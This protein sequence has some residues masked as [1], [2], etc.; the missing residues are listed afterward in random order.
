VVFR[1]AACSEDLHA[2]VSVHL[3]KREACPLR[4][5]IAA[6]LT[7]F[8]VVLAIPVAP[9]AAA[10]TVKVVI[11]VGPVGSSTT[12]YKADAA[13]VAAEARRY[14]SNV[15]TLSTPNATWSK[16]KA[17]AQGASVLVYLGHGN[18][19]PS[20]YPPFQ[21][22]TKD[23]LG[24]D[25]STGANGTKTVYYGESY[26]GANIRLAPNAVVILYHL[27]YASGNTQPGLA[28][29]TFA[30][31][32]LRV[33]NYGAGFIAAGARAVFAEGHPSHPAADYI[34]QL[35]TTSR[36]MDQV[37]RAA[38]SRHGH[39]RGPY[40]SQRT[41]GLRFEMDPD[42][43]TPSGFYRSLVGDLGLTANVVT[44]TVPPATGT[45]PADFVVPGAAEVTGATG[46]GRFATAE[47][48]ADPAAAPDSTL[49]KATRLRLT[50][51]AAPMAD[52]TRVFG[53]TVIGGTASGFV[54]AAGIAPRDSAHPTVWTLDQGT[55]LS[56]NADGINDT[57]VVAVRVSEVAAVSLVVKN[58]AGTTVRSVSAS[59]DIVRFTWDL[60]TSAGVLVPD[61]DYPWTLRAR[62][63]WGNATATRTGS[64]TVD[65]TPPAS[66]AST[67]ST[68][69]LG[70]WS[71]TP[72]TVTLAATDPLTG[73]GS[74][75]WRVDGGATHTYAGPF[76]VAVNGTPHVQYRA[77]DRAGNQEAWHTLA[78]KIDTT[79]PAI[80]IPLTGTAGTTAGTWRGP[81]S[82][83]AKVTDATSGVAAR[84]IS[85][86][87][88]PAVPLGD[89]PVV[90]D[91][92]GSHT[93][94]V[95]ATDAAGNVGSATT[96][97]TIDTVAPVL[98]LP[99]VQATGPVVPTVTPNGDGSTETLAIPF[100]VNEAAT[101]TAV[102]T[103]AAGAIVRRL[104]GAFQAGARQIA[105]N[106]R[107]AAGVPVPDGRYTV[108]LTPVDPA[109]NAGAPVATQVDVYAA[110]AS[111]SRSPTLFF[112]QDG[113]KLATKSTVTF[114]LLSPATV[115]LYVVDASGAAVRSAWTDRALPAGPVSWAWNGKRADGT[116]APRGTYRF[117]VRATNGTQS[118]AAS[119]SVLADA[120]RMTTSTASPARGSSFTITAVTAE[121]LS[122][123]PTVTIRQPGLTAWKITMTKVSSTTWKATIRPKTGGSA[124]AMS[125]T[126]AAR[127]TAGGSNATTIRRTLR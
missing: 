122:T 39:V 111:V 86:D 90:V 11:V 14:T 57:M 106:G 31:A 32:R 15:V 81:V 104:A 80:A 98:E 53:I 38:P 99:P 69:G 75:S 85:V 44:G 67:A 127:D 68:A 115:S 4:R 3:P 45:S 26:I 27:C 74:I 16:V 23:G 73:V 50:A 84:T 71:V 96:T 95:A 105:W 82:A 66:K 8:L 51:E 17:A 116:W 101:V 20:V 79:P 109:G 29:G 55:M 28:T 30:D 89:T 35:F 93:L 108:I 63:S 60:R 87:G 126:I 62:D 37:F 41:P 92:D 22:L 9:V 46:T 10:S 6:A 114:R 34:R 103:D 40:A 52:G 83:A 33:D 59:G 58:T 78:L 18:G 121:G 19:W 61:G 47:A 97:F 5:A 1:T 64:F 2:P 117:V 56:P 76:V 70:G 42:T 125:L 118:A 25:P 48:A 107:T 123:T 100:S 43:T 112:P 102:V 94:T 120:F 65:G 21:T 13:A 113:D 72:V 91:G 88:A 124:G 77:T 7:A 12:H 54:R 49:A 119:A 36:T 24:L 110:L